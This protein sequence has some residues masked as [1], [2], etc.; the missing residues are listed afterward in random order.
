MKKALLLACSLALIV[1]LANAADETADFRQRYTLDPA[2][3][4]QNASRV[5]KDLADAKAGNAVLAVYEIPALSA[6][7]RMPDRYPEDGRLFGPL[8]WIASRDE[9][10]PASFLLYTKKDQ[11]AVELKVSDLKGKAGT[12]PASA[13]DFRVVKLWFQSGSAWY[14]YFADATG[15]TLVP[16]LLLNDENLIR[17]DDKTK[18][19]YVRY[20]NT[21]GDRRYAW[22][23][24]KFETT[25]YRFDNQANQGLIKDA[26]TLQPFVLNTGEFKQ[27]FATIHVPAKAAAG[28]YT[29][30]IEIRSKDGHLAKLPMRVRVLPIDLP[31]PKTA[32][33]ADKN[34]FLCLYGTASRN[35]KILR[36]LAEHNAKNPMGFP[37][38]DVMNPQGLED[39]VALAK[40]TGINT[41][42]I[43]SGSDNVGLAIWSNPIS[44]PDQAKLDTLKSTI[45]K[46]RNL[47]RKV[48]GHT[49]FYS[50]GIDEGG[51]GAIRA[52]RPAWRM[53]HEAG[54]KIMV[55]SYTWR[56][57]LFSLDYLI[58]PGMPVESREQE[59]RLFH[60]SNPDALVGW[61]ANPHSGPENPDYF[62]RIHGLS[63]WKA[64]YDVSANY[65]WWRNNWNDMAVPYEPNLRAIVAVYGAADG[66][67]DTLAWEGIRE[68]L[69]DIRYAT[70][71]KDLA[72]QAASSDDG[73]IL[74]KGRRALSF[75]AYWDG[76]RDDPD[77]FRAECVNYIL[78][79][80]AALNA[81]K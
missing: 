15:R 31:E 49:D 10:E 79:L 57:L 18:D 3:A 12:I 32:Y 81:K 6:T 73:D 42:P 14:G 8:S 74:L 47:A 11:D 76:Y 45:E 21:D 44:K 80:N 54:G 67:I 28:V 2:K 60:E 58:V 26:D 30:E 7:Q 29:G 27:I 51:P 39:D 36:N 72:T 23:S 63:A 40:E 17:T 43:F 75:L 50:Y 62:R 22:M 4:R 71:L 38:I 37:R 61:Y 59:V 20:E 66:V 46:T 53:A 52:Q 5:A 24:S 9:F 48:L 69:D 55:T 35:P 33:D 13:I 56:E 68:G 78:G 25:D 41:R 77:A 65:C 70:L 1:N 16:E 64:G 34:F 19:Y